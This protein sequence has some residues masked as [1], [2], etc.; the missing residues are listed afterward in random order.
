MTG[1]TRDRPA[2][3]RPASNRPASD[4]PASDR[5]AGDDPAGDDPPGDG[6]PSDDPGIRRIITDARVVV[7]CGTGGVGKTTVAAA[8]GLAAA[9][10]GRRVA[11]VTIDPARR[12]A[13]AL[14]IRE[15]GNDPQ[16]VPADLVS[17]G[18][19][20]TGELW[21]LMLDAR[22]TF[23][24]LVA[25]HAT[26]AGQRDRILANPFYRNVSSRLSG[27]QE[28]MAAEK[29]YDLTNDARFV[30]FDTPPARNALDFLD[31]PE[32]LSRFLDHRVYR[33]LMVPTRGYLKAVGTASQL[34]LRPIAKVVGAEVVADA[35]SFFQNFDGMEAGFKQRSGAVAA[36]L[37]DP[38]TRYVL[39][40]APRA[41]AA[42]EAGWFADRL[43]DLGLTVG[44][45][46]V[47]R[48]HPAFGPA[49]ADLAVSA[50][51]AAAAAGAAAAAAGQGALAD[52]WATLAEQQAVADAEA[53]QIATLAAK[54][55]PAP[56]VTVPLRPADVH[57]LVA[58]ADI[59]AHLYA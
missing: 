22:A 11:V 26:D 18:G 52:W 39:V 3:N 10:A 20:G 35:M 33:A 24:T 57:D 12:L 25:R 58:L 14:G 44:G 36:Q 21:A 59:A 49:P 4:R 46:V 27:T 30:L 45:L 13:D 7:C 54:V 8:V 32:R 6:S 43:A 41:D 56:T 31:A 1:T 9:R 47:N 2:S 34:L 48:A 42:A 37:R 19:A 23:D 55:A 53:A 29:L 5:S 38:S 51:D 17:G 28:Y 16:R 40:A 50:S 15:L